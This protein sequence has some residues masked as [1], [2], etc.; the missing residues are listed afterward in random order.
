MA[1]GGPQTKGQI[2]ASAASLRHSHSNTGS[3]THRVRP[4]IEP[5]SLWMLVRFIY[6]E[7]QRELLDF[8]KSCKTLVF[9]SEYEGGIDV[10]STLVDKEYLKDSDSMI[11]P[12]FSLADIREN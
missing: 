12:F 7:P 8:H 2:E 11:W 9:C 3:L 6:A 4:G 10:F 1:C 5:A